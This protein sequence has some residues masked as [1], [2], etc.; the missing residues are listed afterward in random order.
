MT[1]TIKAYA[2]IGGR[3]QKASPGEM[4]LYYFFCQGVNLYRA[5][6]LYVGVEGKS[7]VFC[8]D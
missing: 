6:K 8:I 4:S 1:G 3:I 5:I 7:K 2:D